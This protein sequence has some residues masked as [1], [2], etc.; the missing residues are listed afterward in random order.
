[1]VENYWMAMTRDIP[2]AEYDSSALIA[3]A[4]ADLNRLSDYRASRQGGQ[5]TPAVI[6]RGNVPSDLVGPFISQFLWQDMNYG[7]LSVSQ[8][9]TKC[10]RLK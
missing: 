8:L 3:A 2:F 1:M 7:A 6:F 10:S 5:I 4:C 9:M